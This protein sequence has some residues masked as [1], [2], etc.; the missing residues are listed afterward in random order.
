MTTGIRVLDET[1]DLDPSNE[2]V[3]TMLTEAEEAELQA[4]LN[5]DSTPAYDATLDDA[6]DTPLG[7][8]QTYPTQGG[9]KSAGRAVV[10][11]AW[12]WDGTET[13]L[14]LA[15]NPDGTM[16]DG[17]RRY[18]LKRHCLCCG[19]GGWKAK[20]GQR[21]RCPACLKKGC[22]ICHQSTDPT[23]II[24]SFYLQRSKVPFPAKLYG[25]IPCFLPLCPRAQ[26]GWGF[27]KEEDMRIHSKN[28]HPD[29]YSAKLETEKAG[30][31]NKVAAL[32][33]RLN[34]M[35]LMMAQSGLAQNKENP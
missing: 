32:E 29:E 28:R 22:S 31:A 11:R 19:F 8:A 18:L 10:R 12:M 30:D 25:S 7:E 27:L 5:P 16:H 33:E 2:A 20:S 23:K 26:G 21:P 15:W 35:L 6:D 13:M 24:A 14:P 3:D 9:V 4:L 17:A 34:D 1:T